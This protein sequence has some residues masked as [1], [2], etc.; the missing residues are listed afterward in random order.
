MFTNTVVNIML[1]TWTQPAEQ[2][3]SIDK[4]HIKCTD[5]LGPKFSG[6]IQWKLL[7][8]IS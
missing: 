7:L 8:T 3:I 5:T 1:Q 2:V 6:Q 4:F